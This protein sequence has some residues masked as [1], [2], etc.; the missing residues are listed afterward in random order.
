[1][2]F[3]GIDVRGTGDRL[4]FRVLLLD[5]TGAVVTT[6]TTNLKLYELQSDGTLKSYDFNDNTFNITALTTENQTLTHRQG[7]NS[8]TNTGLWTYALTI[9]SGFTVGNVYIAYVSNSNASPAIQGREWQYG[10]EQGDCTVTAAR[11]NVNVEAIN[12]DT[13]AADNLDAALSTANGIDVNMGQSTPGI[14]SADTTGE[15]L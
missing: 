2:A 1:M 4:V 8:T 11:L 12:T 9:V 10:N 13:T 5:G 15:A 3:Q 6:G 7:N 14:P